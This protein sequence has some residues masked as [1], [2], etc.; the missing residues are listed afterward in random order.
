[1]RSHRGSVIKSA[2][3]MMLFF[4]LG[5]SSAT[6][7]TRRGNL[8]LDTSYEFVNEPVNTDQIFKHDPQLVN[9]HQARWVLSRKVQLKGMDV[10]HLGRNRF[11]VHTEGVDSK[12]LGYVRGNGPWYSN[13]SEFPC[14]TKQNEI[15]ATAEGAR[16]AVDAAAQYWEELVKSQL[17]A[18][19]RKLSEVSGSSPEV[20]LKEGLQI[21]QAWLRKLEKQWRQKGDSR[22]YSAEWHFYQKQAAQSNLCGIRKKVHPPV[23]LAR[24]FRIESPPP[25]PSLSE[26]WVKP[27]ARAPV[28]RWDGLYSIRLNI[29]I[30]SQVLSGQFLI[31]SD[32]PHSVISSIWLEN[33]GVLPSLIRNFHIPPEPISVMG[34]S[35]IAPVAEVDRVTMSGFPI[36]LSEF[37]IYDTDFFLPPQFTAPCCD[38]VLGSDFLRKYVVQFN[39]GPPNEFLI[40][41]REGFSPLVR[42]EDEKSRTGSELVDPTWIETH[43]NPQGKLVSDDCKW[44]SSRTFFKAIVHWD[45]GDDVELEASPGVF[46]P[47]MTRGTLECDQKI[48]IQ[49]TRLTRGTRKT[50]GYSLT[51]GIAFLSRGPFTMDLPHGRLWFSKTALDAPIRKNESGLT[52]NYSIK[53][54]KRV[55]EV[56]RIQPGS[57]AKELVQEGLKLGMSISA[58]DSKP[59]SQMDLWEVD[60]RLAGAYGDRVILEWKTP[61]G[62]EIKKVPLKIR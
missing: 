14:A 3:I 18:L 62:T 44:S 2:A 4:V 51:G 43:I 9:P 49:N 5:A 28:R 12:A 39:P 47:Q 27:L 30:G 22:V 23:S 24:S 55:L 34:T 42:S 50:S 40:W 35:D 61:S 20:A 48:L 10:R 41:P 21:Y 52:L 15:F 45:T 13:W 7:Q 46:S 58:I 60:Q 17:Y 8:K 26:G 1:M 37:H 31:D 32:T 54:K 11:G 19:S 57:L 25:F 33:E 38:G 16:H 53:N 59:V 29:E 56:D 36:D 6:A